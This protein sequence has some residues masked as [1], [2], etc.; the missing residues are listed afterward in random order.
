MESSSLLQTSK[1]P[2]VTQTLNE[3]IKFDQSN[4]VNDLQ[5][6]ALKSQLGPDQFNLLVEKLKES[7]RKEIQEN[8]AS[9]FTS[10]QVDKNE[11]RD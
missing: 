6:Q 4:D 2:D 3:E 1:R 10:N 8:N 11:L 7:L 9:H 5:V